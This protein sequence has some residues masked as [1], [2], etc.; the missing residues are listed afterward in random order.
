M[1]SNKS[2]K[3]NFCQKEIPS[4]KRNSNAV[5]EPDRKFLPQR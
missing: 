1:K 3:T 2:C 4:L 5:R